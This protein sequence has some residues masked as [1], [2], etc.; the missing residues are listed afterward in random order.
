MRMNDSDVHAA[1]ETFAYPGELPHLVKL[2]RRF[3]DEGNDVHALCNGPFVM[4]DGAEAAGYREG[5]EVYD[6]ALGTFV[7]LAWVVPTWRA[8]RELPDYKIERIAALGRD[9]AGES[10]A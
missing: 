6:L 9:G 5:D 1:L 8:L 4:I 3:V 2:A 7:E 10:K